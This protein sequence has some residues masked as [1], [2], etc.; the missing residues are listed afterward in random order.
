M[1]VVQNDRWDKFER[2]GKVFKSTIAPRET[3]NLMVV[4]KKPGSADYT[5]ILGY[6]IAP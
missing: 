6:Q 1:A 5:A 4:G 3:G 2:S